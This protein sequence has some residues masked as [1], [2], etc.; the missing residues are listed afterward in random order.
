MLDIQA[1]VKGGTGK[2]AK[3]NV[4][5]EVS[6]ASLETRAERRRGSVTHRLF[7]FFFFFFSKYSNFLNRPPSETSSVETRLGR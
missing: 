3:G 6:T 2:R 1:K 4:T 7:F 5:L